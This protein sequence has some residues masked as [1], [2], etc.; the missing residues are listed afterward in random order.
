MILIIG[1]KPGH[2]LG[3]VSDANGEDGKLGWRHL[4]LVL[5]DDLY[6]MFA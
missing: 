1:C 2:K 4:Q 3:N 6:E 5:A